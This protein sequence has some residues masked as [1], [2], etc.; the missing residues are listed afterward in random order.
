V[1][2]LKLKIIL[3]PNFN[4]KQGLMIKYVF[5]WGKTKKF[6]GGERIQSV[7]Y[8]NICRHGI[9]S[10]TF[11]DF[12]KTGGSKYV[13]ITK[14]ILQAF[15]IILCKPNKSIQ[16]CKVFCKYYNKSWVCKTKPG[17]KDVL[18]YKHNKDRKMAIF[19][20]ISM[21]KILSFC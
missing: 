18:L 16:Q 10:S 4:E 17:L 2:F 21:L 8:F 13:E 3:T 12:D 9:W 14:Q 6:I 5:L 15:S 7:V 11:P 20:Y 1:P 19:Q